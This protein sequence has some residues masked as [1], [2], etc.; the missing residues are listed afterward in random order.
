[1]REGSHGMS[2]PPI[3]IDLGKVS[4]KQIRALKEGTGDLVDEVDEIMTRVRE[5][6][7]DEAKG[8]EL[9][10]VVLLYKRKPRKQRKGLIDLLLAK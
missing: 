10:P 7:G 8:K 4:K 9:V 5:Q 6:L 1:M 2:K 3:V